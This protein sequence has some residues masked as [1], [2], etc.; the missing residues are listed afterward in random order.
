MLMEIEIEIEIGG[1]EG[2]RETETQ[3]QREKEREE[4]GSQRHC[5]R[6]LIF[7]DPISVFFSASHS[8]SFTRPLTHSL[9]TGTAHKH[10]FLNDEYSDVKRYDLSK[11]LWTLSARENAFSL[12]LLHRSSSSTCFL[13]V[14]VIL[15]ALGF[16]KLSLVAA[17][18]A[19]SATSV[20]QAGT[21]E[22]TAKAWKLKRLYHWYFKW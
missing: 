11:A 14:Y 10:P 20:V 15:Y 16:G 7:F 8:R 3:R 5:C 2:K 18:A 6:S 17:S 1:G 13:S 22:I 12:I 19:Q 9:T 21:K 4:W